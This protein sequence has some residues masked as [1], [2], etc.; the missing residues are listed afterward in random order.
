MHDTSL[1]WW[2]KFKILIAKEPKELKAFMICVGR[3]YEDC[4][5]S[6][7]CWRYRISFLYEFNKTMDLI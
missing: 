6:L 2:K 7:I 3:D 1:P 5:I 4:G